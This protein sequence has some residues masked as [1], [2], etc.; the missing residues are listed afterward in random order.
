MKDEFRFWAE[1]D[2]RWGDEDSYGHVNNA[3]Y[4]SYFEQGRAD[5]FTE[6]GLHLDQSRAGGAGPIVAH[7]NCT[8][9]QPL[10]YPTT[11]QVGV[12]CVEVGNRSF[13]LSQMICRKGETKPVAFGEVVCVWFDYN[14]QCAATVPD[15][16]RNALLTWRTPSS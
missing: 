3:I 12:R 13:K 15:E 7:L 14:Q 9:K 5:F 2:V 11:I 6:M 8:Y 16:L 4:L 10:T 1:M